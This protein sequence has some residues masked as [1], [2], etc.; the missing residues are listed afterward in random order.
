MNQWPWIAGALVTIALVGGIVLFDKKATAPAPTTV[1]A[2][3]ASVSDGEW[4]MGPP[5]APVTLIEY[6][7]FQCPACAAFHPI[8]R[9]LLQDRT[10]TLRFVFRHL[11][12]VTV[13]SNALATARAAEAA[14]QQGQF[15][16][17]YDQLYEHQTDWASQKD[18]SEQLTKYAQ[19]I[20]LGDL[21]RFQRDR[22]SEAVDDAISAD[23]RSADRIKAES[24]PTF[25]INGQRVVDNP[26]SYEEFLALIDAAAT[27][28]NNVQS[29]Q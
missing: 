25:L 16:E 14:G 9:R 3:I 29:P 1:P 27:E 22:A 18:P 23:R 26:R 5:D 8:V 2:E 28:T 20:G 4:V 11:P 21:D 7:D 15:F 24:T 12:L 19:T 17:Y 6:G 10:D 13:H